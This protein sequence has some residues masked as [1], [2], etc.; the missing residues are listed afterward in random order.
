[1]RDYDRITTT[2]E[3][4]WLAQ[5]IARTKKI[6][7]RR[8]KPYWTKRLEKVS[9]PFELRLLNGMN[10]PVP[11]VTVL[12]HKITKDRRA[13]QYRLHIQKVVGF[14]HWDKRQQKP[15]R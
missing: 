6:E 5:I 12:I 13:G 10:P 2:I 14:K 4:G 8:I 3:R 9:V 1:M 11:E 7:Y 15:K